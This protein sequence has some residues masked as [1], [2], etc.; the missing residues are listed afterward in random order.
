MSDRL[1]EEVK[2]KL[3]PG[4]KIVFLENAKGPWYV[5]LLR[6]FRH[7]KWDYTK[8]RYFTSHEIRV[9]S[10]VFDEFV[11]KSLAFPPVVLMMG[12]KPNADNQT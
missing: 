4:G 12:R 11:V 8:A 1:L 7:G 9:V 10:E 3:K 2:E 6:T 5:H